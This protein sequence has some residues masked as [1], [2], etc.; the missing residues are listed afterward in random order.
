MHRT[1]Y[2]LAALMVVG[3]VA[4]LVAGCGGGDSLGAAEVGS[5]AV[6]PQGQLSRYIVV[7]DG[8]FVNEPAKEGLVRRFEGQSVK[9]LH[10]IN[11]MA[12]LLPPTA[13]APLAEEDGVLRIDVDAEVNALPK[14]PWAGGPGNGDEEPPPPQELPWGVD[15]IDAEYAWSV[16]TG[17]GVKVAVVDTG[18]D[19]DHPDLT[20]AGGVNCRRGPATKWDDDNGHGT[21]V[22]GTIAAL[23]NEIGVVGVAPEASLYAVKVLDRTGSGYV[24]DVIEGLE[25]CI[26]NGM[27][28]VNMS[29]STNSDIQSL[30]DACDEANEA[31]LLLVAAAGNDGAAVDY[32]AAYGSAIAV[33]AVDNTD[34]RPSWS[35]Y[36]DA[37]EL[38]G[39]GVDIYSTWK[40]GGYETHSGTSMAAPHVSGT[41]ALNLSADL[42]ATAD[43]LPPAGWDSYTGY[44]L[45]DAEEAATGIETGDDLP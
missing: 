40:G 34:T 37:I 36:G 7:F 25:W 44:G 10:L 31:G 2:L 39:P 12:V 26:A 23:D 27:Q 5:A 18:I 13:Q 42:G 4:C 29:L 32:P 15:R 35:S 19:K 30:H 41:L 3:V 22:A 43:D 14:P 9:H 24:S 8:D 45:V 16:A 17:A 33:A 6:A 11:A 1:G 20:V 28:V 21:H 38:A